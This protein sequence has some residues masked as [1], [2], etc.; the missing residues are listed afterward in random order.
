MVRRAL[1]TIQRDV[2]V[3]MVWCYGQRQTE[4]R[5]V[6][7]SCETSIESGVLYTQGNEHTYQTAEQHTANSAALF[8]EVLNEM[9]KRNL[10]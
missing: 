10:E 6:P 2:A 5:F 8:H 9:E 1:A 7:R 4:T 3:D